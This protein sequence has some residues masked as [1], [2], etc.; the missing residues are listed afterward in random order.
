M[1]TPPP[2]A[3]QAKTPEQLAA[4]AAAAGTADTPA[5]VTLPLTPELLTALGCAPDATPECIIGAITDWIAK[6]GSADAT[7]AQ[8]AALQTQLDAANTQIA[9]AAAAQAAEELA[10]ELS[11]YDIGEAETA[12]L[13]TMPKDARATLLAK[14]PK[15]VPPTGGTPVIQA[16]AEKTAPPAPIHDPMKQ[17]APTAADKAAQ[18]DKLIATIRKE[19][20]AKW[21]DYT[22]AREEAR[23]RAPEL[24]A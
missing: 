8:L 10:E 20:G 3:D 12:V 9:A 6:A 24:F 18:A 16:P 5:P 22:T 11:G 2:A 15:K 7:A 17:A 21:P 4:E 23:R 14:M 13:G 19:G 1:E